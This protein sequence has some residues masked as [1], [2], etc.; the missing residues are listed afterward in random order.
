MKTIGEA[1]IDPSL[2]CAAYQ[3]K[4]LL[5]WRQRWSQM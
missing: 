4:P 1:I 2:D 3:I 5:L